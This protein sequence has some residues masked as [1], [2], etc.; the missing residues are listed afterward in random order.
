MI[1]ALDDKPLVHWVDLDQRLQADPTKTFELTWKRATPGKTE[2][3]SAELTQVQRREIDEYGHTR[4][5]LVFGA[6][7][8]VDRGTGAMTP[9]E[10]R[11]GYAFN[12]ALERTGDTIHTMVNGFIHIGG[13]VTLFKAASGAGNQGWDAFLLMMALISI[14]LGLLNL[15][16]I[17]MLDGGHLLLF[18]V[19][20]ALRRPLSAKARVRIEQAG[21]VVIGLI[22]IVAASNDVLGFL[23]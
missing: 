12:S 18:A 15:L 5:R 9:I 22:V 20:G 6:R 14:N 11:F 4:T 1:V 16:P 10:G 17:P 8:D 23:W 3:L 7:N 19:E 13:P 2:T 21:L